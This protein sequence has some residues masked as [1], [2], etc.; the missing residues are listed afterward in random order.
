[1]FRLDKL[2]YYS[3]CVVDE[4]YGINQMMSR[5]KAGYIP[6]VNL[7]NKW[8][9]NVIDAFDHF[10]ITHDYIKN[11]KFDIGTCSGEERDLGGLIDFI[12]TLRDKHPTNFSGGVEVKLG[13]AINPNTKNLDTRSSI[14][15][16]FF[17]NE[18]E[19]NIDE[20]NC[21]NKKAWNK[22]LH[23]ELE[24]RPRPNYG[25]SRDGEG[26]TKDPYPRWNNWS[27]EPRFIGTFFANSQDIINVL[28]NIRGAKLALDI[29]HLCQTV[30]WGNIFNL[31]QGCRRYYGQL[32]EPQK[33]SLKNYGMKL[34]DNSLL[35]DYSDPSNPE[36][37]LL[38]EKESCFMKKYGFVLREGQPVVYEK[39]LT[40]F[41]EMWKIFW[42]PRIE[43]KTYA[44][45]T[46]GFQ[47]YQG[48]LDKIDG[49]EK[50]VIGS[51]MPGITERY[52]KN[53]KL[54]ESYAKQVHAIHSLCLRHMS[55]VKVKEVIIEPMMDDGKQPIYKGPEWKAQMKEAKKQLLH[56]FKNENVN[57]QDRPFYYDKNS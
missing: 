47:V 32:S 39:K 49:E 16:D 7:K 15:L 24:N 50:L 54:R 17:N 9:Q 5:V 37:L 20:I 29:E 34:D 21:L 1:M 35:F 41:D 30:Q 8:S 36:K 33:N 22:G 28:S 52:I 12:A 3:P 38:S 2:E 10:F 26:I 45:I 44:S 25:F 43:P 14:S 46:P 11:V 6:I 40:L 56:N 51:H 57:I 4:K 55:N 23:L 53:P 42:S 18:Y 27:A 19:K 13:S 31:E 48:F